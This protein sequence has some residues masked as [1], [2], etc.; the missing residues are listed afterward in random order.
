MRLSR[1]AFYLFLE[2]I[3]FRVLARFGRHW[4]RSDAAFELQTLEFQVLRTLGFP[5]SSKLSLSL[6]LTSQQSF[7]QINL[8]I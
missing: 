3:A 2:A 8:A 7:I 4:V 6:S 5:K 1:L